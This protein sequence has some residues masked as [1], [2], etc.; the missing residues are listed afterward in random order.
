MLQNQVAIAQAPGGAAAKRRSQGDQRSPSARASPRPPRRVDF[1]SARNDPALRTTS[2]CQLN[3]DAPTLR[4]PGTVFTRPVGQRDRVRPRSATTAC[5]LGSNPHQKKMARLLGC[6]TQDV[7]S[8]P[9]RKQN[10][11]SRQPTTYAERD[12]TPGQG[13]QR[14]SYPSASLKGAPLSDARA[15]GNLVVVRH[16]GRGAPSSPQGTPFAAISQ[17][18]PPP[19]T[20][21]Q[22]VGN[23]VPTAII[24]RST[25]CRPQNAL[26]VAQKGVAQGDG[27]HGAGTSPKGIH[28]PES[29]TDTTVL[30]A[31]NNRWGA[32]VVQ[33][34]L[35]AARVLV[36]AG[37][38]FIFYES[39]GAPFYPM[40]ADL[41]VYLV[42][43]FSGLCSRSASR[44]QRWDNV[45]AGARSVLGG[46]ENTPSLVW[47]NGAVTQIHGPAVSCRAA[48]GPPQGAI[49]QDRSQ[50]GVIFGDFALGADLGVRDGCG[51]LRRP[52]RT[53]STDSSARL[54]PA[55]WRWHLGAGSPSP[56]PG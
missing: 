30:V 4:R 12:G 27:R 53:S 25:A 16:R 49:L 20:P 1:G 23:G 47:S 3:A 14:C 40:L 38:V 19:T 2:F 44:S 37:S 55:V 48:R 46:D 35:E 18:S 7:C 8:L 39:W 6:T 56:H 42:G 43:A 29:P 11:G 15:Y 9:H 28:Y 41:P 5:D 32:E 17:G 21:L 26:E 54:T 10:R 50:A 34:A 24:G 13:G 31:G 51:L 52:H 33:E 45:C 22:Q 36:V